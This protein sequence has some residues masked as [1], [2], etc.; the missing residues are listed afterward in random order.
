MKV[1][2]MKEFILSVSNGLIQE[3]D[4]MKM[5]TYVG[6]VMLLQNKF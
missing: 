1:T 2:G 4:G 6:G 5:S 3:S